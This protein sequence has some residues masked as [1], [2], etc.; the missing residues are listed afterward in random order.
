MLLENKYETTI[1]SWTRRRRYM[2]LLR[3]VMLSAL[4][5]PTVKAAAYGLREVGHDIATLG[6]FLQQNPGTRAAIGQVRDYLILPGVQAMIVAG[7]APLL[8]INGALLTLRVARQA[9]QRLQDYFLDQRAPTYVAAIAVIQ[10]YLA[11]T[12]VDLAK[13]H[14]DG[15]LKALDVKLDPDTDG[16]DTRR[17]KHLKEIAE[18]TTYMVVAKVDALQQ[19]ATAFAVLVGANPAA[20]KAHVQ[21]V[22]DEVDTGKLRAEEAQAAAVVAKDAIEA[23]TKAA[24]GAN[25][26]PVDGSRLHS[27]NAAIARASATLQEVHKLNLPEPAA[28]ATLIDKVDSKPSEKVLKKAIKDEIAA[29][30]TALTDKL[31]ELEKEIGLVKSNSGT[32]MSNDMWNLIIVCLLGFLIFVCIV[33]FIWV[34]ISSRPQKRG[35]GRRR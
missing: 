13:T 18:T 2:Y 28:I 9:A 14:V 7:G 32:W 6:N 1:V 4:I 27:L 34:A 26:A 5:A 19:E 33:G 16:N 30:T 17:Y 35:R 29:Q 22:I 10:K 21:A 20:V 8:G 3:W 23:L 24:P 12:L 15:V 25:G 11:E 31:K